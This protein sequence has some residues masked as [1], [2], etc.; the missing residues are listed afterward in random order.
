MFTQQIQSIM[1][2]LTLQHYI[3]LLKGKN[4]S[5][6]IPS[7]IRDTI[8]LDKLYNIAMKNMDEYGIEFQI[9]QI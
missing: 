9:N 7:T 3:Y 1:K 2:I 4:V 8:L 6:N 5:I